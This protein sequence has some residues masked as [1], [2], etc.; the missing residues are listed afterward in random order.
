MFSPAVFIAF[1]PALFMWEFIAVKV[2]IRLPK[3]VRKRLF[4]I[5]GRFAIL[6]WIVE[7]LE[8]LIPLGNLPPLAHAFAAA[9]VTA[10]VPE[11]LVKL[12]AIYRF[13]RRELDETGPGVAVL[14]AVG[15]SLGFAVFENK[16]YVFEGGFAVWVLRAV[17]AVPMH[18]IFG[19]VMGSFMAIAWRDARRTDY[20]ALCCALIVPIMFH[21]AYDFLAMLHGFDQTLVWPTILLPVVMLF[22]AIFALLLTNV[23]LNLANSAASNRVSADP[24]G[25]RAAILSV[26]MIIFVAGLI[27]L[28]IEFPDV[29]NIP[30]FAVLP[31]VLTIDITITALVRLSP[32]R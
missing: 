3:P 25:K 12:A 1:L 11:E 20:G 22:E 15:V 21:F 29:R 16:L 5:G 24:T 23:A 13:G 10:A 26:C 17:T 6:A 30:L 18:A 32:E 19:L 28:D 8:K 4:R 27:A 9:L 2:N 14:L 7:A 31:L